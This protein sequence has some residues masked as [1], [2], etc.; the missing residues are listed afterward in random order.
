MRQANRKDETMFK[1]PTVTIDETPD[2]I[3][4][5]VDRHHGSGPEFSASYP[6]H[7]GS[8]DGPHRARNLAEARRE[9]EAR[10]A[11]LLAPYTPEAEARLR[12]ALARYSR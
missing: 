6:T 1:A 12:A 8:Y 4:V 9:A 10:K 3:Y 2:V 11:E 7:R 5:I